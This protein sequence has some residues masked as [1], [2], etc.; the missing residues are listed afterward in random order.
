MNSILP[1]ERTERLFIARK[2]VRVGDIINETGLV[3]L[4][5]GIIV[6]GKR[7]D[8]NCILEEDSDV[9]LISPAS[10]G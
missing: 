2:P 6:N 1:P 4:Y 3:G 7:S 10:G 5:A 8:E 9:I